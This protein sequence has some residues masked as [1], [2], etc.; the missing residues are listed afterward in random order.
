MQDSF[1]DGGDHLAV[2]DAVLAGQEM[3]AF[4]ADILDLG[5]ESTRPGAAEVPVD[6]ELRRVVPVVRALR[7][8]GVEA[9]I[10][11]DTRKAEV[12]R[13]AIEAGAALWPKEG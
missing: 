4:G 13:Q 8:A 1:S 12:A 11:V 9:T 10:S 3:V 2:K 6:E 5:G 7:E